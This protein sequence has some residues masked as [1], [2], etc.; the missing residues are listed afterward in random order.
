MWINVLQGVGANAQNFVKSTMAKAEDV[1]IHD[2]AKYDAVMNAV[3]DDL[4][5][6]MNIRRGYC[7]TTCQPE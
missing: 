6:I 3:G 7:N 5:A 2:Q 4:K 1:T